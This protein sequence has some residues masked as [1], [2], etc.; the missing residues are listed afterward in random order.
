MLSFEKDGMPELPEV[1]TV[2]RSL[3][4]HLPGRRI[5]RVE[6]RDPYV[7]RGQPAPFLKEALEGQT[8]AALERHG[9]LLYF[10]FPE[11]SLIVHLGMTGQLTVRLPDRADTEFLRHAK[12]GLERTLQH[13]PDKHT[14]ISL[15]LDGELELHYRDIR[16]F[17]RVYAIPETRRE[18]VVARFGLG[19]DPL[20]ADY[21]PSYVAAGLMARRTP[22]KAALLDQT[23]L[24]GLGNIY[25]DE[26]LFL[27]GIRPGR[28]AYRVRGQA[29]ARLVQAIPD[30]LRKGLEA[31]GTT[32]R[33]FVSGTGQTGY[34]QEGLQAYGRYGQHCLVCGG[35]LRK[36]LYAGRTTTWCPTCQ[37]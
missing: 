31:G 29:L 10:P 17:G 23:F 19:V 35:V 32:L 24:A 13:A 20:S 3:L 21:G 37:S 8:F 5:E 11:R 26:A 4:D 25:V 28:G 2:R 12:T 34:N 14:H 36:G 16:K 1:E 22:I 18:E 7:L 27:A 33:D 15:Y 30:V 6:I 9:K